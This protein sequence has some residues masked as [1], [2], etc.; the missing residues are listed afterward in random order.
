MSSTDGHDGSSY[1]AA[2]SQVA[3]ELPS[4]IV[5]EIE[6][7]LDQRLEALE[8]PP[9]LRE[10]I[11][12]AVLG[13]GKRLRPQL[14]LLCCEAVSGDRRLALGPAAALE[15]VHGFSLVHDDLPAMDDETLRRGRPTLHVHAG[16]A[17]AVLAGDAMLALAFEL[18]T[19]AGLDAGRAV[20]QC[21]KPG[22]LDDERKTDHAQGQQRQ[23]QE[24]S[25]LE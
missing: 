21:P 15:L 19:G 16:E 20:I 22:S 8:L 13:G 2:V 17:M 5:S 9:S 7:Y 6:R 3:T 4:A 11:R 24:A 18:V 14:A 10:A 12:Y 25:A 1:N 23:H